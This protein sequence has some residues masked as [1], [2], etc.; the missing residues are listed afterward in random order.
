[1]LRLLGVPLTLLAPFSFLTATL[2]AAPPPLVCPAGAPIGSID[3]RV[4]PARGGLALPLKT[5]NRVGE[6]D[7]IVYKPL[8]RASEV[9]KGEVAIVLVPVTRAADADPLVVLEPKPAGARAEWQ[10]PA[11]SSVAVLVYGP[12]GLNRGKVRKF[13]SKDNDLLS[14]LADYAEKT[15]QTEA[16]ISALSAD[17][18]SGDTV[19]AAFRGFASQYGAAQLD[20]SQSVDQQLM[21]TMRTLNPAMANYDPIAPQDSQRIGQTAS[22]AT[23]VAALFFGSPV[24]L[25]AG[26]T[27]MLLELR[28]IAFPNTVFRSSFAQTIPD[29]GLGL[30]GKRDPVPPH[31]KVAYLWATRI[32]NLP[33]PHLAVSKPESLPAGMKATVLVDVSSEADWKYLDRARNWTLEPDRKDAKPLKVPVRPVSD[34]NASEAKPLEF[35]FSKTAVPPGAYHLSA[36]WD[37]DSFPVMGE[38]VVVALAEFKSARLNAESQDRLVAKSG[39]VAVTLSGA[40]F[41]FVKKAELARPGDPFFTPQPVPFVLPKGFRKGVQNSMDIQIN[42]GELDPGDYRLLL[43][44]V[45]GKPHSVPL[46]ILAVPPRLENS[47]FSIHQGDAVTSITLRGEHLDRIVKL[48]SLAGTV[49]LKTA[50]ADGSSRDATLALDHGATSGGAFD[51]KL[52][53]ENRSEPLDVHNGIRIIGPRA[54]VI[55]SRVSPPTAS[56]VALHPG[57]LPSPAILSAML[58]VKD[59]EP[60]AEVALSCRGDRQPRLRVHA[61]ERGSTNS[62]EPLGA[63]NLF[64]TFDDG[65]FPNACELMA[66]LDD[67]VDPGAPE[68]YP[69][70]RI[71]HVPKIGRLEVLPG[72][73]GGTFEAALSGEHL[74]TIERVGWAPETGVTVDELPASVP[75][76]AAKQT[77]RITIP[78]APP[79]GDAPLYVWLTGETTGRAT[80]VTG[81]RTSH[82][83]ARSQ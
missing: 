50:A 80:A 77:L 5:I 64:L 46:A 59:L 4:R 6:G 58:K 30:C 41:Q 24:G 52:F 55:G 21:L 67:G 1:M 27:A 10:V 38:F 37:W 48:D 32:P 9:R 16:V 14:Q 65:V 20:R 28:S 74:E 31:T 40:D 15:A 47:P 35:D 45:D 81:F 49:T 76:E 42:T 13:L 53:V 60:Q 69:L 11:R 73:S 25:A 71:V 3:L 17:T 68:G 79:S 8:L 70:G 12:A 61:G 2:A 19:N 54:R 7:I 29:D 56:D 36:D 26:G 34:A 83:V 51:L 63:E 82:S 43:T 66:S 23:S 18:N 44:Q 33:A 72:A 22:L 75:G 57:E 62:V 78:S 39:R